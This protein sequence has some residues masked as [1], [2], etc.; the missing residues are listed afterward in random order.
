MKKIKV[1][2]GLANRLNGGQGQNKRGAYDTCTVGE[3]V[4]GA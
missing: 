2:H 3:L 1:R 4:A